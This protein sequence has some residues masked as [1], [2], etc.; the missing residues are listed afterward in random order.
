MATTWAYAQV[1]PHPGARGDLRSALEEGL[2]TPSFLQGALVNDFEEAVTA[3]HPEI[4]HI[5]SS[6]RTAGSVFASMSGTGSSVYGFFP[7]LHT[8]HDAA[9]SCRAR[10][11]RAFVTPPR[12]G[13]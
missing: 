10:G 8:A 7:D 5:Q 9:R 4:A 1:N 3:R 6:F 13:A 12:F 11:Y 2:R